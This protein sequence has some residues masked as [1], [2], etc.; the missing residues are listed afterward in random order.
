MLVC[1]VVLVQ[2]LTVESSSMICGYLC[3]S[4]HLCV[5]AAGDEQL[6]WAA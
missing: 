5:Q 6:H 2:E 4:H 1:A 3:R